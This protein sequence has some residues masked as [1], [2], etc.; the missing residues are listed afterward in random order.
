MVK[1]ISKKL[2]IYFKILS[3]KKVFDEPKKK[4]YLIFDKNHASLLVKILKLKNFS[5]LHARFEIINLYIL[6]KNFLNFK[7][8]LLDYYE[9][10]INFVKPKIVITV[11]DNALNFYELKKRFK[12]IIFISIQNGLRTR[13]KNDIFYNI[14]KKNYICDYIFVFNKLIAKE[15]T[16]IVKSKYIVNGSIKNN[17][18]KI[19]KTKF[20]KSFLYISRFRIDKPFEHFSFEKKLL[21]NMEKFFVR[22]N[23]KLHI[24][25]TRQKKYR[26]LEIKFYNE[27]LKNNF[28]IIQPINI[29]QTYNA[30]NY[31]ENILFINSTLGY[32]AIARF[33]KIGIFSFIKYPEEIDYFGWPQKKNYLSKLKF[34]NTCNIN[35]KEVSRIL[36]NLLKCSDKL[37]KKKFYPKIFDQMYYDDKNGLL[38]EKIKKIEKNANFKSIS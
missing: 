34:F 6:I 10:Y 32:E 22:N 13:G 11:V 37:W 23:L 30:I 17:L 20:K 27:I 35:E 12:N 28:K 36:N 29:N 9:T 18:I 4:K 33:K 2:Q 3:S 5:I 26:E 15:Y 8:S 25:L 21:Q 24:L 7:F 38:K 19:K 16:K 1:N 31:Y 14:K